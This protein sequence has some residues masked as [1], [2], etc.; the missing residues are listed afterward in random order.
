MLGQHPA[1]YATPELGVFVADR[2]ADLGDVLPPEGRH[3]LLRAIA[4][5][6]TG[7]QT[8]D[9][10]DTARRWI[11]RRA[12]WSPEAVYHAIRQRI[13]PLILVERCTGYSAPRHQDRLRRLAAAHPDARY[14]HLVRH[15]LAQCRDWLRAPDAIQQLAT[16]GAVDPAAGPGAIDPQ[17]D[18]LYR[19]TGIL[20]FLQDIPAERRYTLQAE[21]LTASPTSTLCGLCDW[22]MLERDL[23]TLDAMLHPERSP[24]ARPGPY[25]AESGLGTAFLAAPGYRHEPRQ[26]AALNQPLPWRRDGQGFVPELVELAR[27]LG[28]TD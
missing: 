17:F 22:L 11:R 28:Y 20:D 2:L 14:V 26:S 6:Y 3:G 21:D 18:W 23:Q 10:V 9:S 25:G 12:L 27:R 19:H 1:L 8:L 16:L 15:P 4:Q 13:A 5:I 7:E 24:Y